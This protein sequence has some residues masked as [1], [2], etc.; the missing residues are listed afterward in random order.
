MYFGKAMNNG[1]TPYI[2]M[3]DH[4]GIVLFWIQQLGN[5]IGFGNFSTGIWIVEIIFYL[6]T[7]TFLFKTCL[8]IT[9]NVLTSSLTILL[10][11][12][13][14]II[15]LSGGN[16]SEEFALTFISIACFYFTRIILNNY[17]TKSSLI[18]IGI[19]GGLT[20]FIRS[21]MVALW[22]VFCMYF[23]IESIINRSFKLFAER[24]IYIFIGGL[25]TCLIVIIYA[26][27][28]G[29][30]DEM[31][32][33]TF[34]LNVQYSSGNS[35]MDKIGAA[36]SFLEFSSRIGIIPFICITF[37]YILLDKDRIQKNRL[38]YFA[39]V[40]VYLLVNFTTVILSGRYYNHYFI[41]M[42]APIVILSGIG[43]CGFSTLLKTDIRR[44]L[45]YLIIGILPLSYSYLAVRDL[46]KTPMTTI[47][48]Q[49][50]SS[51][52]I[53]QANYIKDHTQSSDYIYVH[54][55][56]ANIYLYSNRYS[57]SKFFVLPSLDYRNFDDLKRDFLNDMKNE[58]P[59][60][61]VLRKDSF[62]KNSQDDERINKSLKKVIL[63]DYSPVT[64]FTDTEY[65]MFKKK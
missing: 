4:K 37:I 9:K 6:V 59:K 48:N 53:T 7:L 29:N 8:L 39:T 25:S 43:I 52:V 27:I 17:Q 23:I 62:D 10:L 63:S 15:S 16:Y 24:F 51:L 3:F 32:Y 14:M 30:F 41:T 34:V 64:R 33:Q 12:G 58:P 55:I 11:T 42:I 44:V 49:K 57:N 60:F 20:F 45:F 54:N 13:S 35:L 56:D 46:V 36:K 47:P 22:L 65:L 19:T 18:I 21:N 31:I 61:I 1:M 50:R 26:L 40:F 38:I 5:F 2:D 28:K